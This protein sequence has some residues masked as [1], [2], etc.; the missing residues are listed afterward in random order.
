M[1][2]TLRAV[3]VAA[4]ALAFSAHAVETFSMPYAGTQYHF[5]TWW[6]CPECTGP[7]PSPALPWQ[8][9]VDVT[10]A[11]GADG[12]YAGDALT[13]AIDGALIDF[14]GMPVSATV[15]DSKVVSVDGA[16]VPW[17][18]WTFTGLT[19][20]YADDGDPHNGQVLGILSTTVVAVPEPAT[21]TLLLPSLLIA[22]AAMRTRRQA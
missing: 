7:T 8:V 9:F 21:W 17:P 2:T 12:V 3:A 4:A 5:M 16:T 19:L 11:D 10:T 22:R 14:H 13:I 20:A 18:A 15:H 1:R 6:E